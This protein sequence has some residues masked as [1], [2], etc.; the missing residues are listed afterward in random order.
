MRLMYSYDLTAEGPARD[1]DRLEEAIRRGE[2]GDFYNDTVREL[3]EGRAVRTTSGDPDPL[4]DKWLKASFLV[5][6]GCVA[7][8]LH[9]AE[10]FPILRFRCSFQSDM[11][12]EEAHY[13]FEASQGDI[14]LLERVRHKRIRLIP[15]TETNIFDELNEISSVLQRLEARAFQVRRQRRD[16]IHLVSTKRN[17]LKQTRWESGSRRLPRLSSAGTSSSRS[18]ACTVRTLAF[19]APLLSRADEVIE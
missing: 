9:V 10:L 14:T 15:K 3:P 11:E 6:D 17:W 5:K 4:T 12:F 2:L 16:R 18:Q 1:V 8:I 7:P 19:A 13:E